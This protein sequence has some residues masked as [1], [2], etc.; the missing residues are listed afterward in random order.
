MLVIN[1]VAFDPDKMLGMEPSTSTSWRSSRP[2]PAEPVSPS[3]C[4][5]G[6]EPKANMQ[7]LQI[8]E[9]IQ[10]QS[11]DFFGSKVAHAA[12]GKPDTFTF[13][14]ARVLLNGGFSDAQGEPEETRVRRF[15]IF[16][17]DLGK[18]ALQKV[19]CTA[20]VPTPSPVQKATP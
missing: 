17:R 12:K 16:G 6:G 18:L 1:L 19:S 8:G 5:F 9:L 4:D 11:T 2:S 14:D 7:G 3:R 13:Q 15:V 20:G 10:T